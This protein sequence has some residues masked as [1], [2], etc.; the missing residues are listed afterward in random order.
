MWPVLASIPS[1]ADGGIAL[2]PLTL[3]AYGLAY[4]VGLAAAIYIGLKLWESRGGDRDLVFEAATWGFPAGIIGGRLYHVITS[5]NELPDEWWGPFAIW[6]GG[7]G[8][9]G[10]IAVGVL[11]GWWRVHR[12]GADTAL[13]ADA[14]APS[15]LVAQ[16]IGRLGNYFNQEIFGTPTDLPWG[17]E[18]DPA[19]R[20]DGYEQFETF[21]PMF[22]Y[23]GLWC[24]ALAAILIV[25][26]NRRTFRPPGLFALYVAGYSLFRIF[27]ETQRLDPANEILGMRVNFWVAIALV[28]V[29]LAAFWYSQ[30]RPGGGDGRGGVARGEKATARK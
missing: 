9:W 16:A 14:A 20:P 3:H 10:G 27:A 30:R 15:I 28:L 2:G 22:L 6:E 18:I 19:N 4:V 25:L 21:H 29:G 26:F 17:L 12:A 7:M 8:I 11:V 1:P 13:F 5:W 24:L 23:E